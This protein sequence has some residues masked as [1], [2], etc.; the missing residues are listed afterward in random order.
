MPRRAH[1]RPS[2]PTGDRR[3]AHAGARPAA[4]PPAAGPTPDG[5]TLTSRPPSRRASAASDVEAQTMMSARR[6]ST[7]ATRR[8]RCAS[9]TSEPQSW[10]T[11][12][13][14]RQERRDRRREPVGVDD[15][16]APRRAPRSPRV[17]EEEQREREAEPWTPAEVVD[18]AVAVGDPVVAERPRARRPSRGD[19]PPGALRRRPGRTPRRRRRVSRVRRREDDDVHLMRSRFVS[20]HA[21]DARLDLAHGSPMAEHLSS[22]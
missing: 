19:P 3:R 20:L 16:C 13:R 22:Q 4:P 6:T 7:R 17:G 5:T 11:S 9:A 14:P 12:G 15:V 8:A 18:D 1:G 21:V 10:S 2:P